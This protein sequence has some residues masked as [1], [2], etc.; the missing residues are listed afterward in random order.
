MLLES[1][2]I[3][4]IPVEEMEPL[5]TIVLMPRGESTGVVHHWVNSHF[6][7]EFFGGQQMVGRW[8]KIG[9]LVAWLHSNMSEAPKRFWLASVNV[10]CSKHWLAVGGGTP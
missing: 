3:F 10:S 7:K 9:F 4:S 2:E 1:L 6:P 5:G 8:G